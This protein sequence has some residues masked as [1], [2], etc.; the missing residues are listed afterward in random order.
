MN[1]PDG[2]LI[3]A[4]SGEWLPVDT[5][6]VAALVTAYWPTREEEA[7]NPLAMAEALEEAIERYRE[8]R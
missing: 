5:D 3:R 6:E 4:T 8:V 7:P 2:L 1:V